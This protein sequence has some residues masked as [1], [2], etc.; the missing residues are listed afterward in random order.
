[1]DIATAQEVLEMGNQISRID[2]VI[3][4]LEEKDVLK[5]IAA[6]LPAGIEIIETERRNASIREMTSAFELNLKAMSLLALLVGIFLI[7]NTIT[8]SV[9]RRREQ[10]GILRA[11]GTTRSEIFIMISSETVLLGLVGSIAGLGLGVLL[12]WGTV[13]LVTRTVSDLFFILSVS[14]MEVTFSGLAKATLTGVAAA[15]I[16]SLLPAFEA[17]HVSP[18][19]A[20]R[21]SSVEKHA[22]RMMP[23]LVC[24]GTVLIVLGTVILNIETRRLDI[25]FSGLFLVVFGSALLVPF[26]SGKLLCILLRFPGIGNVPLIRWAIR[27]VLRSLSRT[28]VAIAA[29]MIAV[30]VI[31]GVGIMVNSFRYSVLEWLKNT[32]IADIYLVSVNQP[33]SGLDPDIVQELMLIDG[34]DRAYPAISQQ[35]N[36]GRFIGVTVFAIEQEMMR[37]DWVWTS[38]DEKEL[39]DSFSRGAVFISENLAWKHAV[40]LEKGSTLQLPTQRGT[41]DFPVAGVFR[42]FSSRQG[43]IVM[44]A[45]VFK[46]NWQVKHI[47]GV[48]LFIQPGVATDDMIERINLKLAGK[49][50]F[51]L[52]ANADIRE[53]AIVVFNRTFRITTALQILAAL[54]AFIGVFNSIMAMLLER[55][56]EIGVVRANGMTIGQVWRLVFI[57]SGIIGLISGILSMPLGVAM[58]WVLVT[59]INQ[60]SFGWTL[61]F[62]LEPHYLLLAIS[63]ALIAS[64]TAGIYPAVKIGS[65]NIAEALRTE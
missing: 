59:I 55:T 44:D 2:L 35:I 40:A 7:Y 46:Q 14:A 36:S 54:V 57:E 21:R 32:I 4:G 45:R 3:E 27:N 19:L 52:S 58:A 25:S 34:V 10:I 65:R 29:M 43:M 24:A 51:N 1:M 33:A 30:S 37:R 64:L 15:F 8:F 11:L 13:Q 60:R 47:S 23:L 28:A 9:V 61:D 49:H 39:Y 6:F 31:I 42:D 41:I 22:L 17:V 12:G 18:V 53:N 48:G 50:H 62:M 26:V 16:A 20:Q 63:I 56:H 38:G 5:T